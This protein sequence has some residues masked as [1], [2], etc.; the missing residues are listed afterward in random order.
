MVTLN[1]S[2]AD[3]HDDDDNK[4]TAVFGLKTSPIHF[5]IKYFY[6][7]ISFLGKRG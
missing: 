1:F 3:L 5:S 4:V 2:W 6:R 7:T